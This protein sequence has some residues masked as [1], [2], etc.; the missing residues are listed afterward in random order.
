[1]EATEAVANEKTLPAFI[2]TMKL[3]AELD[4]ALA[5]T[6]MDPE[7]IQEGTR[8]KSG[9]DIFTSAP[10]SIGFAAAAAQFLIGRPGYAFDFEGIEDRLDKL[11]DSVTHI[12]EKINSA[13]DG[14]FVD[15]LA[16][17][18][19]ISMRSGRIGEYEREFFFRAFVRLFDEARDLTNLSP[20]WFAYK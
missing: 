8:F 5:T 11:K 2:E 10:A 19:K 6:S 1:M 12:C 16:L 3:L 20:C 14:D 9:S 4:R 15:Y 17:N 7:F 13:G 18:E